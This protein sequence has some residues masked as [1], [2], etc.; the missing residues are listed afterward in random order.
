MDW[1]FWR[2]QEPD[3]PPEWEAAL[4]EFFE[5][6][7]RREPDTHRAYWTLTHKGQGKEEDTQ[8]E[9]RTIFG[10]LAGEPGRQ[11]HVK[12]IYASYKVRHTGLLTLL[13]DGQV[14][15]YFYCHE[16][17][18]LSFPDEGIVL[19]PGAALSVCLGKGEAPPVKLVGALTIVGY[20]EDVVGE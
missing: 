15:G 8:E 20:T 2:R 18:D 14:I 7:L 1:R 11:H 4:A 17:R 5:K 10:T 6:H 13:E 12:G 9:P 19:K 3:A 16:A